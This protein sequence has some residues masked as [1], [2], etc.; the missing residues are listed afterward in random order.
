M[1]ETAAPSELVGRSVKRLREANGWSQRDFAERMKALGIPL[2]HATVAK[3]EKGT[4]RVDLDELLK[5]AYALNVA[6]VH[7]FVPTDEYIDTLQVDVT[8][9]VT[10]G[11]YV[12]R[13]WIRGELPIADQDQRRY[14]AFMPNEE[15]AK[16][17]G[18]G[19]D[20]L[21]GAAEDVR[22]AIREGDR[23]EAGNA[24]ARL[25]QELDGIRR[26]QGFAD[27][28]RAGGGIEEDDS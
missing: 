2:H 19:A 13:K 17:F 7:L 1:A 5:L 25:E 22:A 27:V 24:I 18:R 16:R 12:L 4:R 28:P 23:A 6:P 26:S 10:V 14:F 11:P 3:V 21:V 8:P 20:A 9:E 15:W